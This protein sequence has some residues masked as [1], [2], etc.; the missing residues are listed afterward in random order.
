MFQ[1]KEEEIVD[2]IVD[3]TSQFSVVYNNISEY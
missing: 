2:K 3:N 1:R